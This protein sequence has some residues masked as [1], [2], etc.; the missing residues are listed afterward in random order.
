MSNK[1]YRLPKT[2]KGKV[3]LLKSILRGEKRLDDLKEEPATITL[4]QTDPNDPDQMIT[5]DGEQR[6]SRADL[7]KEILAGKIV[8]FTLNLSK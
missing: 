4:W 2:K 8:R 3:D 6:M 7:E 1:N 5:F